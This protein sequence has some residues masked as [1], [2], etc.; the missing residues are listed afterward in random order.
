MINAVKEWFERVLER[1]FYQAEIFRADLLKG[2]ER[3]NNVI[4]PKKF[5]VRLKQV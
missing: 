4:R 2:N 5:G 1:P 3:K